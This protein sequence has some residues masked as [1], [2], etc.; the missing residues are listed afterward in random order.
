MLSKAEKGVPGW[1]EPGGELR[2]GEDSPENV[3]AGWQLQYLTRYRS[4]GPG[5]GFLLRKKKKKVFLKR[6]TWQV[7]QSD[8]VV[9][10]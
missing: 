5:D 6:S 3:H 9:S 2:D 7:T 1:R 4:V 8:T 10:C